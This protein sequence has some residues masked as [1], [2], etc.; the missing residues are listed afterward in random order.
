[1]NATLRLNIP[2]STTGQFDSTDVSLLQD[3]GIGL[4]KNLFCP[5]AALTLERK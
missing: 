5:Y 4:M 3:F 1:M 2:P